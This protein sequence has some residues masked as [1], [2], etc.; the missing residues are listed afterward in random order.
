MV[1]HLIA[2][3]LLYSP[4]TEGQNKHVRSL[5][6][7]PGMYEAHILVYFLFLTSGAPLDLS[8]SPIFLPTPGIEGQNKYA[9]SVLFIPSD[10]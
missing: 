3:T 6:F 2:L 1:R 8:Y 4:G 5:L 9:R 7:I 10:I